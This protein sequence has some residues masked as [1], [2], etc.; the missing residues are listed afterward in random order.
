MLD[1]QGSHP[2]PLRHAPSRSFA[3]LA[4]ARFQ[5][6][7]DPEDLATVVRETAPPLF[8]AARAMTRDEDAAEDLVQNT[9][10]AA[11]D[12][13]QSYDPRHPVVPWL[14]G[15]LTNRA[16]RRRRRERRSPD[17]GRLRREAPL[18]D[19]SEA[20]A[21]REFVRAVERA[22]Q[23]LPRTYRAVVDL[24]LRVG[25]TPL[26]ISERLQRP[27]STVRTQLAR[28][29]SKLRRA[30]GLEDQREAV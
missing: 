27:R 16:R 24:H 28:G 13:A 2:P 14:L 5:S 30:L 12:G 4:F 19:P 6:S 10:V 1:T 15:I 18:P 17:P 3:D 21:E 26:E 8:H 9:F 7:R 25:L 23:I 20:L 11:I 29:L 22:V